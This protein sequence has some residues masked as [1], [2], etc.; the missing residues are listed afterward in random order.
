M[1]STFEVHVYIWAVVHAARKLGQDTDVKNRENASICGRI[2]EAEEGA[3]YCNCALLQLCA[4]AIAISCT[5]MRV[6]QELII[7]D[8]AD[9]ETCLPIML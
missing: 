9:H 5:R 1:Q 2:I 8:L 6:D 4:I 3:R 7:A